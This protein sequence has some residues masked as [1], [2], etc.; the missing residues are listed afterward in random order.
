ML[1]VNGPVQNGGFT[2]AE[3]PGKAGGIRIAAALNQLL[4]NPAAPHL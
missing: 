1:F 2:F 3:R 4:G